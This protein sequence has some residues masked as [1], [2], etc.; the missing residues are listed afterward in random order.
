MPRRFAAQLRGRNP[1]VRALSAASRRRPFQAAGGP[2]ESVFA[3]AG[4]ARPGARRSP[5]PGR[6]RAE[7]RRL[8]PP[9]DP[10]RL[11]RSAPRGGFPRRGL[12][13]RAQGSGE[14]LR[15]KARQR[16]Q[17][18]RGQG[19]EDRAAGASAGPRPGAAALFGAE[20]RGRGARADFHRR[21]PGG[22][23]R[24]RGE[25]QGGEPARGRA[26]RRRRRAR[27][28]GKGAEEEKVMSSEPF[29]T[30]TVAIIGRPNVGKSTLLNHLI[31]AHVAITSRK[32][33]TSRHRIQGIYTD[34]SAQYIFVDTPG[35]QT[36]HVNAL[37]REMNRTVGQVANEVDVVV[38]VIEGSLR[39]IAPTIS[40]EKT[41][42]KGIVIGEKGATLK[43][44]GTE[45]RHAMQELFGS[46]VHLELW[47]RVKSGWADS[48]ISLRQLGYK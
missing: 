5:A 47:V 48:E 15:R 32:A 26:G 36:Q 38:F 7:K 8:S 20:D 33:Q 34:A 37:N 42:H 41:S 39:R 27:A 18:A 2:G 31:G 23:P 9:V 45:A 11:G 10:R 43:R 3:L 13:G 21:M 4:G 35:F 40:V 6:G 12:R 25:R 1:S 22:R 29:R 46:R 17:Q 16:G 24:R 28:I 44:I 19:P 30:G 14:H